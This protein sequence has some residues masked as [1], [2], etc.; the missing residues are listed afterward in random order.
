MLICLNS[1]FDSVL[2][3]KRYFGIDGF[4]YC[5]VAPKKMRFSLYQHNIIKIFRN[6]NFNLKILILLGCLNI[7]INYELICFKKKVI[8]EL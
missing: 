3:F 1:N 8:I 2:K 4:C 5:A 6:K 7:I